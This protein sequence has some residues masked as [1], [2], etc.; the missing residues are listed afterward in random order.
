LT[1]ATLAGATELAAQ[2]SE[3]AAVLRERVTSKGGTTA[4]A[5]AHLQHYQVSARITEA[6]EAAYRRAQ[7]LADEFGQR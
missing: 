2:S 1:I 6:V 3:S 7:T 4:A 5:L